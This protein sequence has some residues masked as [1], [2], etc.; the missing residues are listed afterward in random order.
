MDLSRIAKDVRNIKID[1][2]KRG[3]NGF[4]KL[5]IKNSAKNIIKA[6][7]ELTEIE[8]LSYDEYNFPELEGEESDEYKDDSQMVDLD[9]LKDEINYSEIADKPKSKKQNHQQ[10]NEPSNKSSDEPSNDS[11]DDIQ[12]DSK[13]KEQKQDKEDKNDSNLDK[14]SKKM[15]TQKVKTFI[16]IQAKIKKNKIKMIIIENCLETMKKRKS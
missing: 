1:L 8:S 12:D 11:D 13:E 2:R 15:T 16:K 7:S 9:D 3:L 14:T 5:R 10:S 6:D 4:R